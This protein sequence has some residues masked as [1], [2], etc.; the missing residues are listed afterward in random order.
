MV[1]FNHGRSSLISKQLCLKIK[2]GFGKKQVWKM[3]DGYGKWSGGGRAQGRAG[4][5][6]EHEKRWFLICD[7]VD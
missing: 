3:Q 7:M 5:G 4:V 6:A 2:I 1:Y